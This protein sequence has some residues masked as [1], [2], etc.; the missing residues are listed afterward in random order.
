MKLYRFTQVEVSTACVDREIKNEKT[1]I[2]INFY[3]TNH[4]VLAES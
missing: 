2:N 3:K 1:C 4:F